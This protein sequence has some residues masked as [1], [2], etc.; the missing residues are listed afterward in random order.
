MTMTTLKKA[1][2]LVSRPDHLL[3]LSVTAQC[4]PKAACACGC[5]HNAA[6]EWQAPVAENQPPTMLWQW[7]W[8]GNPVGIIAIP[9]T[10]M[11]KQQISVR[12]SIRKKCS[13]ANTMMMMTMMVLF[14][15]L[16]QRDRLNLIH[17]LLVM[18]YK[19]IKQQDRGAFNNLRRNMKTEIVSSAFLCRNARTSST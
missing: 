10:T 9:V 17:L 2:W 4:R 1:S 18:T 13:N 6:R 12:F 14:P 8:A 3:G 15:R 11:V 5:K 16:S 19:I 7:R